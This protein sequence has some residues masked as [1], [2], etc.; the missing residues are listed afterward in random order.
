MKLGETLNPV[1]KVSC[2]IG[3]ADADIEDL[4]KVLSNESPA[5]LSAAQ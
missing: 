3:V 5:T 4:I 2:L 1:P